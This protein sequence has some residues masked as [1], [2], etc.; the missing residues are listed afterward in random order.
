M[1]KK[2]LFFIFVF[3]SI[4]AISPISAEDSGNFT[5]LDNMIKENSDETINLNKDIQL[6]VA[7]MANYTNGIVINKTVEINGNGHTI[8][9]SDGWGN[10]VRIFNITS[11]GQLILKNITLAGGHGPHVKIA[12][13]TYS[14]GGAIYNTGSL[15]LIN[16]IIKENSLQSLTESVVFGGAIY[17]NNA[18]LTVINSTFIGNFAINGGAIYGEATNLIVDNSVF[19]LNTG[20]FGYTICLE[21]TK[22]SG[23]SRFNIIN[24][25]FTKNI[26]HPIVVNQGPYVIYFLNV[27]G[28]NISNCSFIENQF[29]VIGIRN[30]QEEIT[31]KTIIN[32]SDN[33]FDKNKDMTSIHILSTKCQDAFKININNCNFTNSENSNSITSANANNITVDNCIFE[34]NTGTP[35]INIGNMDILNSKFINNT[36]LLKYNDDRVGGAI[37]TSSSVYDFLTLDEAIMNIINSTFTQNSANKGGALYI[38]HNATVNI[39]NSNF[40]ENYCEG[41]TALGGAIYN[42]GHNTSI[43][44]VRFEN[45]HVPFDGF[46][47]TKGG[48]IYNTYSIYL[49]SETD[50]EYKISG[51]INIKDS[52]FINHVAHE[53]GAIYNDDYSLM[54]S[55]SNFTNNQAYN[56]GAIYNKNISQINNS[57]IKN[58]KATYGGAIYTSNN[59][60]I[61]SSEIND[62]SASSDGGAI[63]STL[64]LIIEYTTF[65]SNNALGNAGAIFNKNGKIH[66]KNTTFDSNYLDMYYKNGGAIAIIDSNITIEN[67]NFMYNTA[68]LGFTSLSEGGALSC[69]NSNVTIINSLFDG[70]TA[71]IG[72]TIYLD[73][74]NFKMFNSSIS[75]GESSMGSAGIY[76]VNSKVLINNLTFNN[77]DGGAIGLSNSNYEINYSNFYSNEAPNGAAIN[78]DKSNGI[79]NNSKIINNTAETSGVI[80]VGEENTV[81]IDNCTFQSNIAKSGGAIYNQGKLYINNSVFENNTVNAGYSYVSTGGAISSDGKLYINNSVFKNNLAVGNDHYVSTGGAISILED[82]SLISNSLFINNTAGYGG[83]IINYEGSIF[84]NHSHFINNTADLEGGAVINFDTLSIISSIFENNTAKKNGSAIF[85]ESNLNVSY[86]VFLNN[87]VY[88]NGTQASLNQNWWATNE[89]PYSKYVNIAIDNWIIMNFTILSCREGVVSVSLNHILTKNGEIQNLL[90]P[91]LL[92][93]RIA[94]INYGNEVYEDYLNEFAALNLNIS[95]NSTNITASID[96]VTLSLTTINFTDTHIKANNIIKLFK[97]GTQYVGYLVDENGVG[98]GNKTVQIEINGVIYNRTTGNDGKFSISINL[99]PGKY[100]VN[101]TYSGCECYGNSSTINLITVLSTIESEDLI[102]FYRNDT[103]FVAIFVNGDGSPLANTNVSFNINGR[104]YNKTTG[105]SGVATLNIYLNP[106]NYIITSTNLINGEMKSNNVTVKSTIESEDLIKYYLNGTQFVAKFLNGDGSPLANT[107]VSFNINGVF[108]NKTTNGDGI[109]TLNINLNPGDY[110]LTSV[111]PIN[112]EMKSNNI[113]VLP[114]LSAEDLT[115]NYG[116]NKEFKATLVGGNGNPIKG[117]IITFNVNGVFYNAITD[118]KGIASLKIN[119]LPNNYIITSY[120]GDISTSNT[121]IVK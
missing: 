74:T 53:G 42:S 9:G 99:N 5:Y 103:H 85:S 84:I 79:I 31:N 47:K 117:E 61:S 82:Y 49:D 12:E 20:L 112:G 81:L 66:L 96:G 106:G 120:Y 113:K 78:L 93:K 114:L 25:N 10:F 101:V 7:E 121:I 27:D 28:G 24:S 95:S 56:G 105:G 32:I 2:Y 39:V 16:S 13:S 90:N 108:Y 64:N 3:I 104:V 119:L 21:D 35:I 37:F 68:L 115:M 22:E 88:I 111:N 36:N 8:N 109:A 48:A 94:V 100:N 59:L 55:G 40:T 73:N 29:S 62:N 4:I 116:E 97:N 69:E 30:N 87:T 6:N 34:N 71:F 19:A 89:N 23:K 80:F 11:S 77:N 67:S 75:N 18:N 54:I 86:S 15:T 50:K 14:Y 43:F 65:N 91:E 41:V 51:N 17:N 70:N 92:P 102:K 44:N 107:N 63:Y 57:I 58:N 72:G 60:T 33:L 26:L 45:N 76:A 110:V 118:E 83:A 46:S 1:K 98:I 52:I 38:E